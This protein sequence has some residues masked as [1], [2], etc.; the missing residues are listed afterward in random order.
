MNGGDLLSSDINDGAS[1]GVSN[2]YVDGDV[3]FN[4]GSAGL[5]SQSIPGSINITGDLK[6]WSGTR[7]IYGD[8]YVSGDFE[9]KDA[10][11]HGN[12][13]VNG[14]LT[15]DWTP[16]LSEDSYIYYTGEIDHPDNYNQQIL[17]KCIKQNSVPEPVMPEYAMPNVKSD[18]WYNNSGYVSGGD[19]ADNIKIFADSYSN[20]PQGVWSAENIIIVASEGDI[21]LTN[22]NSGPVSGVLFAPKGKVI[23]KGSH[24]KGI[25]IARDGFEVTSGGS[26]VTF[27]NIDQYITDP[28][29]YPF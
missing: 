5:G 24:F 1:I 7:D 25:V 9:L 6:L 18:E 13:Y 23:F 21:S 19:L 4:G 14:N 16:S 15:L 29:D 22:F 26:E 27:K 12:V 2:I 11:I 8:V 17:D 20:S 28:E 3:D 10:K